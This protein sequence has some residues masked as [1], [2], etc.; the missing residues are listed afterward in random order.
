M[1]SRPMSRELTC[2]AHHIIFFHIRC[3]TNPG[4]IAWIFS[5][6]YNVSPYT[7]VVIYGSINIRLPA[8]YCAE[9]TN[10][11]SFVTVSA[12]IELAGCSNCWVVVLLSGQYERR[13][14][15][16]KHFLLRLF[17]IVV[18]CSRR[19]SRMRPRLIVPSSGDWTR[20]RYICHGRVLLPENYSLMSE[21]FR[22]E[23]AD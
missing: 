23:Y 6:P 8:D 19:L 5:S 10:R 3:P 11:Q 16:W 9:T 18:V 20:E 15:S 4:V 12:K 14:S 7:P 2:V 17:E 22:M 21:A 1:D 13:V